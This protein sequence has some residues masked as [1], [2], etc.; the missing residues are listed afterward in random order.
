MN[1]V[2]RKDILALLRLP[3]VGSIQVVFVAVLAL[4]VVATWPQQGIVS[5]ASRD[6]D[7]LLLGLML[8]QLLLLVLLVPGVAAVSITTEREHGTLEMLYASRLSPAQLIFGKLLSTIGYPLLLLISGLPFVAMLNYRGDV[9]LA[10]LFRSYAILVLSA[11]LL[12]LLSLAISSLCRQSSTSLVTS[13]AVV[14]M[15]CGGVLVPAAIM[16]A[17]QGGASA[18]ALHYLRSASPVAA[19]LSLLRP[20][21]A[22]FGGRPDSIDALTGA[23]IP[24]LAPAW[25]LFLP[26]AAVLIAACVVTLILVLRRPPTGALGWRASAGDGTK[27]SLANRIL[28]LID[29][30]RQRKPIGGLNPMIVKELRTNQLRSGRWMIRIF[31]GALFISLGL[32]VMA[33]YGGQTEHGDLL[34]Y[35]ASV[36]VAF[37]IGVIALIVPSLTSPA[38]SAEIESETFEILRLTPL[39]ARRIFWG[40]LLPPLPSALLPIVAML[41]AYG[42]LCVIDP[43]YVRAV[44]LMLPV[45]FIAV[46]LYCTLGLVCSMFTAN[47]ARAT[48]V[49]YLIV[50]AIVVLPLLAWWIA[51]THLDPRLAGW[52]AMPSPLVMSLALLPDGAPAV[53]ML[54]PQHLILMVATCALLLVIASWRLATMLRKGSR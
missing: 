31:Y 28:V 35:V 2:L 51:G 40:K 4:L 27:R 39:G 9:D 50:G 23:V 11:L 30:K 44:T 47:T 22:D 49:N 54:L 15:L 46:T 33:M 6:R 18:A 16:L 26:F 3:R 10:G 5:L 20:Q 7:A 53:A 29:P 36:L 19:L 32:A 34:R 21:L 24:G 45:F 25:K 42:A 38:V 14:L 43:I 37:Q 52:L 48:V 17:S 13:Y 12:A 41:P 8:G 1:P